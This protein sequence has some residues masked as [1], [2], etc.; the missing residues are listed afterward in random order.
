MFIELEI[1]RNHTFKTEN[2]WITDKIFLNISE[3]QHIFE[4]DYNK[5]FIILKNGITLNSKLNYKEVKEKINYLINKK[6]K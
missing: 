1:I 3:I 6:Y 2:D 5:T 4:D